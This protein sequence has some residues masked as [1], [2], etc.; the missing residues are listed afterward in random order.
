MHTVKYFVAMA[1][2]SLTAC[3]AKTIENQLAHAVTSFTQNNSTHFVHA[4]A[5]LNGDSIQDAVVL[6][7]GQEWCGSGGCTMLVFEGSSEGFQL[8]SK[9]TVTDEPVRI[10]KETHHGWKTLTVYSNRAHRRM[11]FDGHGYPPNPSV[12]PSINDMLINSASPLLP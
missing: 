1:L 6:L 11:A 9:S 12:E 5:D 10:I 8:I 7:R 4:L 3:S 2:L